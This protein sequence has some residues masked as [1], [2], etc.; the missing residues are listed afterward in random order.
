M[1]EFLEHEYVCVERENRRV[2]PPWRLATT[3]TQVVIEYLQDS[4]AEDGSGG[5]G[6]IRIYFPLEVTVWH[7]A[8]Q[9]QIPRAYQRG[10][11]LPPGVGAHTKGRF[12]EDPWRHLWNRGIQEESSGLACGSC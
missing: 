8:A 2:Q 12:V 7:R 5:S 6:R 10:R 4:G 11:H 3:T 9:L 1:R